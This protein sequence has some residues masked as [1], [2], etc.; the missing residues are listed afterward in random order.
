MLL[1][2]ADRFQQDESE[3][4]AGLK[5]SGNDLD[6]DVYQLSIRRMASENISKISQENSKKH[7]IL[8]ISTQFCI[9]I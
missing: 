4:P 9:T 1:A 7:V 3:I 5:V 8:K 6:P 2:R